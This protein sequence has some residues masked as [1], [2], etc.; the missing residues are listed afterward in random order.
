[1]AQEQ[2]LKLFLF[3]EYYQ[4][5]KQKFLKLQTWNTDVLC[6]RSSSTWKLL[7]WSN[8]AILWSK[9]SSS[10]ACHDI[11]WWKVHKILNRM[12]VEVFSFSVMN[13]VLRDLVKLVLFCVFVSVQKCMITSHVY[14]QLQ[15]TQICAIF[16]HCHFVQCTPMCG[17]FLSIFLSG[18]C[19]CVP[20]LSIV[21]LSIL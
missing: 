1:M 21:L 9:N 10:E 5:S 18:K 16:E 12:K 15:F 11:W 2:K 20:F 17:I 3:C 6:I 8:F 14:M 13:P 7:C 4:F 19:L